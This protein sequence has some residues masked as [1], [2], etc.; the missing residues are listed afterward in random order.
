[1][2][3]LDQSRADVVHTTFN[4]ADTAQG[5][6]DGIGLGFELAAV[7]AVLEPCVIGFGDGDDLAGHVRRVLF[8]VG[9]HQDRH[10]TTEL[11]PKS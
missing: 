9:L 3:D 7:F 1:M 11:S 4:L 6:V 5:V 8:C 2:F 10:K